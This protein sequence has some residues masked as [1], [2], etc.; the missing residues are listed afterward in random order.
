M[1]F[2]DFQINFRITCG[3]YWINFKENSWDFMN[4][5]VEVFEALRWNVGKFAW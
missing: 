2:G 1:I 3:K 4:Q 5:V